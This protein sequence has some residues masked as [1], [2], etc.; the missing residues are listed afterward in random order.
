LRS[1]DLVEQRDQLRLTRLLTH[2]FAHFAPPRRSI[3]LE[4]ARVL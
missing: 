4:R 2:L 3:P 1:V